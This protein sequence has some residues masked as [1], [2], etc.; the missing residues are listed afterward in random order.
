M[1]VCVE[2]PTINRFFGHPTHSEL[3]GAAHYKLHRGN[4]LQA[5]KLR[6]PAH[7]QQEVSSRDKSSVT[8]S[9]VEKDRRNV[10]ARILA[11]PDHASSSVG[12]IWS[13]SVVALTHR[14]RFISVLPASHTRSVTRSNLVKEQD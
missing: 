4:L 1:T 6:I 7:V 10:V 12:Y 13:A 8:T 3:S 5:N 9:Q 14:V 2:T 11:A